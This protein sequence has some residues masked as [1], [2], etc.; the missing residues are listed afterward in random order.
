MQKSAWSTRAFNRCTFPLCSTKRPVFIADLHLKA[1]PDHSFMGTSCLGSTIFT[2]RHD[3]RLVGDTGIG[4]GEVRCRSEFVREDTRGRGAERQY[5]AAGKPIAHVCNS[6][7]DLDSSSSITD[8]VT[9][10]I[11]AACVKNKSL[12]RSK[13]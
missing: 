1:L 7:H 3:N 4:R 10:A 11:D 6:G 12:N 2:G 5:I 9:R 13:H 8:F